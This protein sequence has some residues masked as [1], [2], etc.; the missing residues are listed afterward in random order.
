MTYRFSARYCSGVARTWSE[1]PRLSGVLQTQRLR[2]L[3]V[4]RGLEMGVGVWYE[5]DILLVSKHHSANII[6]AQNN[7]YSSTEVFDEVG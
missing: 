4:G 6:V 7:R 5:S 1:I 3:G 2:G